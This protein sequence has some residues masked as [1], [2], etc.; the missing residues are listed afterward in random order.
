MLQLLAFCIVCDSEVPALPRS[1]P[2][3][4]A[5]VYGELVQSFGARS[6]VDAAGPPSGFAFTE[7]PRPGVRRAHVTFEPACLVRVSCATWAGWAGPHLTPFFSSGTAGPAG[8]SPDSG[9]G[10]PVPGG[11]VSRTVWDAWIL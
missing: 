2:P 4:F 6:S 9:R 7:A 1:L 10:G 8:R 11:D 5:A 3:S